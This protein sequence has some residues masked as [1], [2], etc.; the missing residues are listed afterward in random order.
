MRSPTHAPL[1]VPT[2]G[3]FGASLS[4]QCIQAG[5]LDEIVVHLAPMLLGGGVRLYGGEGSGRVDLERVSPREAEQ[6]TDLRSSC[7]EATT[8]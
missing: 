3:I 6:L 2:P 7:R 4:R 8:G 1:T 5:L